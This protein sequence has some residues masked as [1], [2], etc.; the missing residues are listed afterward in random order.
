MNGEQK[1]LIAGVVILAIGIGKAAL[2]KKPIDK[3]IVGGV[4]FVLLL[5]LVSAL[6]PA[7]SD[8]AGDFALLGM[9]T[10]VLVD[11]PEV[12]GAITKQQTTGATVPTTF[13][14]GGSS[15]GGTGATP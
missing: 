15:P 7:L 11:A 6:G 14:A 2:D 5:S 3:P 1:I 4:T 9:A 10:V 13:P 12:I 8:L